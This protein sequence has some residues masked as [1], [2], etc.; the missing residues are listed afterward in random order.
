MTRQQ[1]QQDK[2]KDKIFKNT[3]EY[4]D[5][6]K[7]YKFIYANWNYTYRQLLLYHKALRMIEKIVEN[8]EFVR[9]PIDDTENCSCLINEKI[10][11]IIDE[12]MRGGHVR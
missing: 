4:K 9:C 2:D 6:L 5:F 11:D 7:D 3:Q 8:N 1:L 10:L 12:V